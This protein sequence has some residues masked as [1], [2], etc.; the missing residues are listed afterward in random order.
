ME[1]RGKANVEFILAFIMFFAFVA[2]VIVFFNPGKS[3]KL[4]EASETYAWSE[5]L[6]NASVEVDSYSVKINLELPECGSSALIE[7]QGDA[8]KNARVESYEGVKIAS[9]EYVSGTLHKVAFTANNEYAA[10]K[11][12]SDFVRSAG[13]VSGTADPNC[14]EIVSS[15]SSKV[16]SE[17]KIK[18]LKGMYESDY[19]GLKKSVGMPA[20]TNFDFTLEFSESDFTKVER[21]KPEGVE[22]FSETRRMEVVRDTGSMG[23]A[24]LTIKVW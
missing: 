3:S 2:M 10:V 15:F 20:S 18:M 7:I 13:S 16:V 11:M 6:R 4:T 14:Y 17:K 12:S 24:Y 22:V 5:I 19:A 8:D 23:F 21:E 9:T 1:K